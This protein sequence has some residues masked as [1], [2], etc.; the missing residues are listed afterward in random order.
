LDT[1]KT[2]SHPQQ[3]EF[4]RLNL[5]FTIM[6]KRKLLQLVEQKLVQGWDDP[7]MPTIAGLR[8]RG[9]TPESIRA[10]CDRIGVAKKDSL[11]D[12][13]LLENSI[14]DD[15][16]QKVAR[17]MCVLR[18]LRVVIENF[19]EGKVEELSAP[20]FPDDP[21]KMGSRQI[22]FSRELYIERDDFM[23]DPPKNF[24]RLGPDREVRL[25]F[26]Y[27]IKCG[28]VV[29]DPQTGEIQE[30]RCTY[31][32]ETKS[33]SDSTRTVKGTIHWVSA[34]QSVPVEIRLY[35]RLFNQE[36]PDGDDFVKNL[37]PNSLEVLTQ[38]RGERSLSETKPGTRVQF[39]RTGYFYADPQLTQQGKVVFNRIV[40]LRDS[41]A[42]L[43]QKGRK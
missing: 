28:G 30:L 41:W 9:Y 32:P 17:T 26:G 40:S 25:R 29:K 21:E 10:F 42:K 3:I 15:L 13:G 23:E 36:N 38:S 18:P 20:N 39:E 1:L 7:R 19:P 34:E 31:D 8:R 12:V 6:S 4:A 11:V 24:Y 37:N 2:K 27:I 35:D 33:G 5:S 22:P 14:R 43:Q 16:N